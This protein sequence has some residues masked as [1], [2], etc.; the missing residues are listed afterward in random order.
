MKTITALAILYFMGA[1]SRAFSAQIITFSPNA[2]APGDEIQLTGVGFSAGNLTVRFW[3]GGDGVVAKIVF[4][5]SDTIMTMLVPNGITTGPISIQQGNA[6]PSLS[7]DSFLAIGAGP[8]ITDFVP[9]FGNAGTT[10]T[11]FG[12]H[13]GKTEDVRFNGTHTSEFWPSSDGTVIS[14]RVPVGATSGAIAVSTASGTSNS[15]TS[16]IVPGPGPFVSGFL[17][18][19][20]PAGTVVQIGG[21]QLA[22]TT[23]VTFNGQPG[24]QLAVISDSLI[25]VKAPPNV[26][27]GPIGVTT[28]LGSTAT[29]SDFFATPVITSFSPDHGVAGT[30]VRITGQNFIGTMGVDFNGASATSFVVNNNSNL[31]AVVPAGVITGPISVATPAGVV[32]S[33]NIFNATPVEPLPVL[34]VA[35]VV[36]KVQVSWPASLTNFVLQFQD[37]F[38]AKPHWAAVT[39]PPTIAGDVKYVI[40]SRTSPARMYRLHR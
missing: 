34:A 19:S 28:S 5:N 3:N 15:P 23:K 13:L 30:Q 37:G 22:G 33:T 14:T 39:T 32:T 9:E 29:S 36:G 35:L 26:T 10:V 24:L 40:D 8:F 6:Q 12:V 4:I 25:Q 31:S 21:F 27:T 38:S 2:G 11:I 1:S 7:A 17:P 20:G 18:N 16:F